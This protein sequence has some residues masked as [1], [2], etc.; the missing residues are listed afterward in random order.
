MHENVGVWSERDQKG[1]PTNSVWFFGF[2]C[3]SIPALRRELVYGS[4]GTITRL[5][6]ANATFPEVRVFGYAL[7]RLLR[8]LTAL[9]VAALAALLAALDQASGSAVDEHHPAGRPAYCL[10]RLG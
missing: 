8:L 4:V 1:A 7:F 10:D 9:L 5:C 6:T 2:R 3:C